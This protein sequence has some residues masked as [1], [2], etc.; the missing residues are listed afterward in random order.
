VASLAF[1]R[2]SDRAHAVSETG[3]L[4]AAVDAAGGAFTMGYTTLTLTAA[5]L[6]P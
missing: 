5:R 1:P 3:P 6:A 4:G 2:H